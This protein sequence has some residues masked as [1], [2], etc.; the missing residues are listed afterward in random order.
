[1]TDPSKYQELHG[2]WLEL[3]ILL[4]L[5]GAAVVRR[6]VDRY[7]AWKW[8]LV[9]SGLT[10]L[11]CAAA[12]QDF[13][14]MPDALEADDRWHLMSRLLG[15]D[16]EVFV[17]D[18]LNAPLLPMMSL[19]YFLANLATLRTKIRRFSFSWALLAESLVLA[20]FSCKTPWILI[21]LVAVG[22]IPPYWDLYS[23]KEP[24]RAFTLHMAAYILLLVVGQGI[25]Q[26]EGPGK[27]SLW[28]II[29]LIIAV[30]IRSGI[31][32]L[33]CWMTHLYERASL[34]TALLF[35]MPLTGAYLA[36]RLVLPVAPDFVL[37]IIGTFSLV[38]A[39]YAAGMAL[40]QRDGRRFFCYLLISHSAL[41]LVG[42]E[43]VSELG[44]TGAL[45]V[46]L[47]ATV[48]LGGFGL[49]LRALEAR[50]GQLS[51]NEFQGLYEHMPALAVC[52]F[53]TGLGS[54]G[55]PGTFGFIGAE[56]L[57]DGAVH[58]LPYV[59]IAV[60]IT[61]AL[62]GIAFVKTYFL[63]FTGTRYS[64]SISL[65]I[66]GRERVAV[67]TLTGLII[68]GGLAPQINVS[69]RNQ[70]AKEILEAR[71]AIAGDAPGAAGSASALL[72]GKQGP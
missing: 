42:L 66:G 27:H 32:P 59:G 61:A 54:I 12:W 11:L 25:V 21:G 62:N 51:L 57:V 28:A 58:S 16:H 63:L 2:P 6:F 36:V 23:R 47:S 49:T 53:L 48:S 19:L 45:C 29:P 39:V 72:D 40:V 3:A 41:V 17:I 64:S 15:L 70:A 37:R 67:L 10:F 1:V 50:R 13:G 24:T 56:L 34:G 31:A 71:S 60:V 55:F 14:L 43:I 18:H 44:L 26:L 35:T 52:F 68:L 30:F 46:W 38:T 69:S 5:V 22:T 9:F 65:N 20:T 7:E 8:S 4:P 33:H